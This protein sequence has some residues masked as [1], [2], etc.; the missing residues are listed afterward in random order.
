MTNQ[1]D[2]RLRGMSG[3]NT[4][5]HTNSAARLQLQSNHFSQ[6][7]CIDGSE[8]NSIQTGLEQE[9]AKY[10]YSIKAPED[11]IIESVIDRYIPTQL[12]GIKF[13]PQTIVI[14]R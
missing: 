2:I 6:H 1:N 9:M 7:L 3:I 8:P 12:N 14:Y 11:I 5:G 13:N 10:T 4:F